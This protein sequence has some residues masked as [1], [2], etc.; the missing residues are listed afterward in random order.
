MSS[1][2]EPN[3]PGIPP[4]LRAL[5]TGDLDSVERIVQNDFGG[6]P[7]PKIGG[8]KETAL[9]YASRMGHIHIIDALLAKDADI[10]A[11]SFN[12]DT[13][14]YIAAYH[15]N[16]DTA[17]HLIRR[18]CNVVPS[19]ESPKS[20]M[21]I[22]IRREGMHELV[23][24][25]LDFDQNFRDIRGRNYLHFAVYARNIY[26]IE[27]MQQK[28]CLKYLSDR[29]D[30]LG[31]FPMS[32]ACRRG[33]LDIVTLMLS[34]G[35][36]PNVEDPSF[37]ETLTPLQE[38]ILNGHQRIVK[39]L[40]A[41]GARLDYYAHAPSV[42]PRGVAP[43]T[44]SLMT[45]HEQTVILQALLEEGAD[46]NVPCQRRTYTSLHLAVDQGFYDMAKMIVLAN[47]NLQ[48][49]RTWIQQ[50]MQRENL[51]L[52]RR[53]FLTWLEAL[54][55]ETVEPNRLT[56]LCRDCIRNVIAWK[57][58]MSVPISELPLPSKLINFLLFRD[59]T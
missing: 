16:E 47:C 24:T 27:L 46:V 55:P 37:P 43:V 29:P 38:A 52:E 17:L 44:F 11:I 3:A 21:E 49:N 10:N 15:G 34:A 51:S 41:H 35:A 56:Y 39:V 36:D 22:A 57:R 48:E 1:F 20:V 32:I 12:K 54:L 9:H 6:D 26:A 4:L 31:V 33:Y 42:S 7:N 19:A 53:Q 5:G 59:L 45:N 58:P 14:L 23:R 2:F 40:L 13:P 8:G 30:T 25:L 28:K 50:Y 18:G